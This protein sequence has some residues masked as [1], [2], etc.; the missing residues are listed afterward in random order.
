MRK[1]VK[2]TLAFFLALSMILSGFA[3][4]KLVARAEEAVE[5][6][7]ETAPVE[8]V[9]EEAAEAEK[10]ELTVEVDGIT[11]TLEGKKSSFEEGKK[12]SIQATKIEND[13]TIEES[14][15]QAAAEKDMTVESYQ[16]FDIVLMADGKEV[17]PL[18]PV[19]VKFSGDAVAQSVKNSET[20]L[21]VL[22][23]DAADGTAESM[24]AETENGDV[25]IETTHFS[26]YVVVELEKY[27]DSLELE[28]QHWA[29][30]SRLNGVDGQDGLI[31]SAGVDG[32]RWNADAQLTRTEEFKEIYSSDS[33]NLSN[34][35]ERSVDSISKI[36]LADSSREIKHYTV[37]EVWFLKPGEDKN[38]TEREDWDIYSGDSKEEISL[39]KDTVIRMVYAPVE[40]EDALKQSTTFF[41]YNVTDGKVYDGNVVYTND[42]GINS[43][44]NYDAGNT[45]NRMAVGLSSAY[46]NHSYGG[47]KFNGMNLNIGNGRFSTV[48]GIVTGVTPDD[49]IYAEG[50]YDANL[51]NEEHSIGKEVLKNY[52]LY[53]NQTGDTYTLSKVY[54]GDTLVLNDL[55]KFKETYDDGKEHIFSN[56]F[57]PLDKEEYTGM[58]PL[59]GG[60]ESYYNE[61]G[62]K[63]NL[64]DDE[65]AHNWH[66]GM[67]YD[68]AFV[69]GDYTGPLNYYFRGDDDFW[70]FVDGELKTDIGGI[71]SS[72]GKNLDLNYLKKGDT[73][74]IH[75]LTII[76]AERGGH[77]S[78]CYMEF[79]IPNVTPI[80]PPPT[81]EKTKIEVI[82]E[83]NDDDNPFRP[84]SV[85]VE[86]VRTDEN[87]LFKILDKQTLSEANNWS[88]TWDDLPAYNVNNH[89]ID[90]TYTVREVSEFADYV[91]TT[92]TVDGVVKITN[93]LNRVDIKL[94]KV[95]DDDGDTNRP[96][97]VTF[98]LYADGEAVEGKTITLKK[99][100][101]AG[102]DEW[103]SE[104]FTSLPKYRYDDDRTLTEIVYTVKEMSSFTDYTS[105]VVSDGNAFTF[106]NV[107]ERVD[108]SLTKIWVGDLEE[109]R[110]D[111]VEFQLYA[112]GEKVEGKIATL[113]KSDF[114]GKDEWSGVLF[115]DLAKYRYEEG[116]VPVEIKYTV[117]EA[118]DFVDYI[119]SEEDGVNETKITNTLKRV[120][121]KF[122]K[123]WKDDR[124]KYRPDGVTF[125]LFADGEAV[126][127]K[128]ITLKKADYAG[129][130]KWSGA[131]F[132]N[133]VKYRYEE[134]RIP[135]EI[136]YTV[137][138]MNGEKALEVGEKLSGLVDGSYTVVESKSILT[139]DEKEAGYAE[140]VQITNELQKASIK[141]TKKI[142]AWK[143]GKDNSKFTF[144]ITGPDNYEKIVTIN[145]EDDSQQGYDKGKS[146]TIKGLY[147]GTYKVQELSNKYFRLVK[148]DKEGKEN[149]E[150][151]AKKLPYTTELKVNVDSGEKEK[152]Y[153]WN[154]RVENPMT[155]I[156]TGTGA[157]ATGDSANLIL[158]TGLIAIAVI[159]GGFAISKRKKNKETRS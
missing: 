71:H 34:E 129:E 93:S 108:V 116:R 123:V 122:T 139:N 98:Q 69:L 101:Y 136:K 40:A 23:V 73:D 95:W 152:V 143:P 11:I 65:A 124:E 37:S 21:E 49:V 88:Y 63:I 151:H 121:V 5:A 133:L 141:I 109:N 89:E 33:I 1:N 127:G 66:F 48:S 56:N 119:V 86:L 25:I 6:A 91:T 14:I 43:E 3:E 112:D 76:Y 111:E 107:L 55:E 10:V 96:D 90:Y 4:Q 72:V 44:E 156:P 104:G 39:T 83:W 45:T 19:D 144:K 47:V 117:K 150:D 12:Y 137:K 87:G 74:Q 36:I 114:A 126:E 146:V 85:E 17:Q 97:E 128:T 118:S 142:N 94:T 2:R 125:Q 106:T 110:P 54:K 159:A 32:N 27:N 51:F 41:D 18:G 134:G 70:L 31:E 120:A 68:F 13:K 20:E 157:V 60:D 153:F 29:N 59:F 130:S 7:E 78:T 35:E 92:E 115:T 24:G 148:A 61:E 30:L 22:H 82:K 50:I 102:K 80:D 57:W 75:T 147:P 46:F 138:E 158:Y 105:T 113:K 100:D 64:S 135:V 58:D 8:E 26:V 77:G 154:R 15:E 84:E 149:P 155:I 9:A 131:E 38:S 62:A 53:F 16:A 99:S 79:T 81:I 52:K 42:K 28:I 145:F 132:T 67:R 103:S 140:H